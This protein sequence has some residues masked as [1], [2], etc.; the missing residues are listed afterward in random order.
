MEDDMKPMLIALCLLLVGVAGAAAD[1]TIQT[2][3]GVLLPKA[4]PGAGHNCKPNAPHCEGVV[5]RKQK[6]Q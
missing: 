1:T 4:G 2:K 3:N 5:G 6:A